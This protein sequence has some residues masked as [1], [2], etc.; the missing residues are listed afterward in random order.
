MVSITISQHL[1]EHFRPTVTM[2]MIIV[3]VVVDVVDYDVMAVRVL[4]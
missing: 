3:G 4:E 2:A 1:H